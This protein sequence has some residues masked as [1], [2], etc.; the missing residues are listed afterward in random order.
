MGNHSRASYPAASA[1]PSARPALQLGE[2]GRDAADV[3]R[4]RPALERPLPGSGAGRG[5]DPR[6]T[7]LSAA[8]SRSRIQ[9]QARPR[10][11][12][13]PPARALRDGGALPRLRTARAQ[14]RLPHP[15]TPGDE[16][17]G[18]LCGQYGANHGLR[19]AGL[20]DTRT[21]RLAALAQKRAERGTSDDQDTSPKAPYL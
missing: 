4:R 13:L 21:V 15:E 8:A 6:A 20:E 16:L 1:G 18:S 2:A 11:V 17:R 14:A 12:S 10:A 3:S 19:S 9:R 7:R 5:D